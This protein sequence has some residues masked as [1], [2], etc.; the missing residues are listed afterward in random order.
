VLESVKRRECLAI[1]SLL[2][3]PVLLPGCGKPPS[4]ADFLP[5]VDDSSDWVSSGEARVFDRE[6]IFSL[7]NGQAE[8]FFAYGF[9][10]VAVQ[11]YE[12][13]EG[14]AVRIEIW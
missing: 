14:M 8:A 2:A 10:Q 4:P 13:V 5:S 12:N 1:L 6:T 3:L 9:E 11:D 7:V